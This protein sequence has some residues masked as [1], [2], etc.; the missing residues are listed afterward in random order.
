[1]TNGEIVIKGGVGAGA[2]FS[3]WYL[4]HAAQLNTSLQTTSLS[5][6]IIIGTVS[7][8]KLFFKKRKVEP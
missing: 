6:G 3:A 4:S 2:S 8:W 1:M 7:L 5:L